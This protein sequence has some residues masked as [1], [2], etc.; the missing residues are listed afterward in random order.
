LGPLLESRSPTRE[1][2]PYLDLV[3]E[4]D[5]EASRERVSRA[6]LRERAGDRPGARSDVGCLLEHLPEVGREGQREM[7]EQWLERL[8]R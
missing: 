8:T 4:L 6:M 5:P 1:A 3:L 2:L 7:L